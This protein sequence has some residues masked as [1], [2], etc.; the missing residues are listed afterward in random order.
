MPAGISNKLGSELDLTLEY[1]MTKHLSSHLIL[2]RFFPGLFFGR[3]PKVANEVE[4]EIKLN[5]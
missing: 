1:E 4:F 2:A 5:M 3:N